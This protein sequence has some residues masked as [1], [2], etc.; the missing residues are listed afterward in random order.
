LYEAAVKKELKE[1]ILRE[2]ELNDFQVTHDFSL[3]WNKG[4][5]FSENYQEVY[6]LLKSEK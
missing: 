5:I 1:G 4:S 6:R 2:I 3:V